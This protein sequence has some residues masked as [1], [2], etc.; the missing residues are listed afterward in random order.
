MKATSS[1]QVTQSKPQYI[2]GIMWNN[3]LWRWVLGFFGFCAQFSLLVYP[4]SPISWH[5]LAQTPPTHPETFFLKAFSNWNKL[6]Q[7]QSQTP[8][9]SDILVNT[10][11]PKNTDLQA[12]ICFG[13]A[14]RIMQGASKKRKILQSRICPQRCVCFVYLQLTLHENVVFSVCARKGDAVYIIFIMWSSI[15]GLDTW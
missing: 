2:C 13:E 15:S 10:G 9:S 4:I 1:I 8:F 11:C 12:G 5:I 14:H 7:W 3:W 6:G